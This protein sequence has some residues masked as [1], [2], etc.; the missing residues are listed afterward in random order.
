M[1]RETWKNHT[2][3]LSKD[4]GHS[5]YKRLWFGFI[6]CRDVAVAQHAR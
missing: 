5:A 1:A 2:S 6:S 4:V 3:H